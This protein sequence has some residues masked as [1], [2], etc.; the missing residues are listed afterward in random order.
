MVYG[1]VHFGPYSEDAKALVAQ[2]DPPKE[3]KKEVQGLGGMSLQ[4]AK[5]GK[6]GADASK[7][8]VPVEAPA[9]AAVEP[10]AAAAAEAAAARQAA[11]LKQRQQQMA[12]GPPITVKVGCRTFEPEMHPPVY[13]A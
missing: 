3:V 6:K 12:W 2:L 9:P 11:A 5:K 7:A 1:C 4:P 8:V 10:A 13:S